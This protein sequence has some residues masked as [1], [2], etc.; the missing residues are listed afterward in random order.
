MPQYLLS[1]YRVAGQE[2]EPMTPEQMQEAMRCAEAVEAE[3]RAS[4]AFVYSGRLHDPDTSTVVRSAGGEVVTTDGPFVET[5][6]FLAGFYILEA[7]DL[8]GALAWAAKA[9]DGLGIAIEV[10]PFVDVSAR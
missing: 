1:T 3:M 7:S 9:A 2:R 10:R 5:K 6:E 8:D 4:G